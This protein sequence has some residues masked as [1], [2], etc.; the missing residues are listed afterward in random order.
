MRW[1]DLDVTGRKCIHNN[2]EPCN[3]PVEY[4]V[5]FI[6]TTGVQLGETPRTGYVCAQ[7]LEAVRSEMR[8][9]LGG[10]HSVFPVINGWVTVDLRFWESDRITP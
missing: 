10:I 3:N 7:H 1:F 2:I 5:A 8:L 6:T 4:V 9:A